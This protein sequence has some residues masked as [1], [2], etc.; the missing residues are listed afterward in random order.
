MRSLIRT[1]PLDDPSLQWSRDVLDRQTSHLT[2][3][4]DDLLDVSRIASG[5]ITLK[6]EP[7]EMA[8]VLDRALESS[9][10]LL[11]ARGHQLEVSAP[12][13]G[14]RVEGDLTRLAQVF[15]NLINNAAKYTPP[16]GRIRVSLEHTGNQAM[17]R[18]RD[19]GMGMAPDLTARVFEPF[20]QGERGLERSEGG[21]GVGLTLV[22]ALVEMHGGTVTASSEGPGRGSEFVVRLPAVVERTG[23]P[24]PTARESNGSAA[25][26]IMVVDDNQDAADSLALLLGQ[27][28][29]E[30]RVVYDGRMALTAAPEFQPEIVILDLGL[31][32]WNGYEVARRLR[33]AGFA[34]SRL[35]AITGYGSAEDRERTTSAGFAAHL[36]KP[37]GLDDLQVLFTTLDE[38]RS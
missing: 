27:A 26:R 33:N 31:P 1:R 3:L 20:V 13:D 9:R 19:N 6:T 23:A 34:S 32:G 8:V 21:L 12:P 15:L 5:K 36:V 4:V 16:G 10:P 37:V 24:A 35:V 30:V 17:V 2:R 28:G 22:R 11:E 25:R 14:A 18:V 29:H 38:A 7:L